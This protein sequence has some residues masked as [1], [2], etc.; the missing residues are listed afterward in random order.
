[1]SSSFY[2]LSFEGMQTKYININEAMIG[3]GGAAAGL[4]GYVFAEHFPVRYSFLPGLVVVPLAIAVEC[5]IYRKCSAARV[6]RV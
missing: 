2:S 6:D 4:L 3:G 5:L 1:M